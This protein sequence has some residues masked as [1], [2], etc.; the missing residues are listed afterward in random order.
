MAVVHLFRNVTNANK[1]TF[2]THKIEPVQNLLN[3]VLYEELNA[4][5]KNQKIEVYNVD[6]GET[7]YA[8]IEE[9]K[10]VASVAVTVNG[11]DVSLDY[12]IQPDDFLVVMV[13]PK[14]TAAAAFTIGFLAG[15]LAGAAA[16][17]AIA[18]ATALITGLVVGAIIG[19]IIGG[20]LG[21]MF[22]KATHKNKQQAQMEGTIDHGEGGRNLPDVRG[23]AN[24]PILG[25]SFPLLFGKHLVTPFI[26]GNS[27]NEIVGETGEDC[28]LNILY[29][30]GY[31]PLRLTDFKVG[32][33]YLAHNRETPG[34]YR[35]TVMHGTLTGYNEE[36][37]GDIL[38]RWRNNEVRLEI[39]QKGG[40]EENFDVYGKLYPY[41]K[42]QKQVDAHMIHIHDKI[43]D[44]ITY[45]GIRFDNGYRTNTVMFTENCPV[46]IEVEIDFQSGIYGTRTHSDTNGNSAP[47]YIDIPLWVAVQWRYYNDSN[48]SSNAEDGTGWN[49]FT[50]LNGISPSV[51]TEA[52]R[53]AE[54]K[55]H[56]GNAFDVNYNHGWIG[57]QAFNLQRFSGAKRNSQERFVARYD[58]TP[59]ECAKMIGYQSDEASYDFIEVR[60]IR[61][62]PMYQNQ[63]KGSGG[64][65][66]WTFTDCS[67][68][69]YLRTTVF[70]KEKYK[71]HLDEYGVPNTIVPFMQRPLSLEMMN[72]L[73]CVALRVKAD[74]AGEIAGE[75]KKFNVIGE[76]FAPVFNEENYTWLPE[77]VT[78]QT[79]W[80]GD[81]WE[82]I[83]YDEY[84]ERRQ[85]GE[86][87]VELKSGNDLQKKLKDIAFNETTYD[88]EKERYKLTPE[89][90]KYICANSAS[91][92]LLALLGMHLGKD[93]YGYEDL[94]MK[95]FEDMY[96]FCKDVTD[97][98]TYATTDKEYDPDNPDQL[99]HVPFNCNGYIYRQTKLES[100]LAKVLATGRA[101]FTRDE[102][103]RLAVFVDKPRD[104]PVL[105]INQQNCIS[106]NNI[107]S[108][109]EVPSGLLM[110]F[111]DE[112]DN[113]QKNTFYA[114]ADGEDYRQPKKAIEDYAIDF[115][116]NRRQAWSLGRYCLAYKLLGREATVRTIGAEGMCLSLGDM[117]SVSDDTLLIGSDMG[118]RVQ[119]LIQ[120][121]LYIYGFV[122]DETFEYTGEVDEEG[123]SVQGV[124]VI[125][126]CEYKESRIVTIRLAPPQGIYKQ[127][128][129][130]IKP[131][132]GFTNE[133][134]FE[135]PIVR[136]THKEYDAGYAI[137][138]TY[139]PKTENIVAFGK[140]GAISQNYIVNKIKPNDKFQFELTLIPYLAESYEYG[141]RLPVWQSNISQPKH[142]ESGN[143]DLKDGVT[144]GDVI[145]LISESI[146]NVNKPDDAR[147]GEV[148]FLSAIA[149][150]N[151]LD[152]AWTFDFSYKGNTEACY[153]IRFSKDGGKT[154][155]AEVTTDDAGYVVT[156]DGIC[157]GSTVF[158]YVFDRE[159]DGY[160]E[161][162]DF[163]SVVIGV[164]AKSKYL[165]FGKEKLYSKIDT[166][167]YGTWK[168]QQPI[169]KTSTNNRLAILTMTQPP[170]SDGREV[171][172]KIS[173]QVEIRKPG[174]D[175]ADTFFKPA[176]NKDP[177]EDELNYRDGSGYVLS[178]SIFQQSL[179]FSGQSSFAYK[180][181][182]QNY[183]NG[184]VVSGTTRYGNLPSSTGYRLI[185]RTYVGN[186]QTVYKQIIEKNVKGIIE[187]IESTYE[188]LPNPVATE[189][190]YRITAIGTVNKADPITTTVTI[191][192]TSS[193][194][195]I[196]SI[197]TQN[198]LAPDSVT[199][200]KIAT[201]TIT[202]DQIAAVDLAAKGATFGNL[203]AEGFRIDENNFWA[204]KTWE[205]PEKTAHKGQFWVGGKDQYLHVDPILGEGNEIVGY[206]IDFKVGNFHV[207]AD[208]SNIDGELI[209]ASSTNLY[210]R[211][212]IT[213][214]GTFYEHRNE[215][216]SPW[217]AVTY[218]N[219]AGTFSPQFYT[220]HTM[221]ITNASMAER[222][223]I[224][225][226]VGVPYLSPDARVYH[227]DTDV[228][229]QNGNNDLN[230]VGTNWQLVGIDNTSSNADLA[231]AIS[232]IAPYSSIGKSIYGRYTL[233]ADI[234][235]TNK[236][237]VDFW[238]KYYSNENQDLFSCGGNGAEFGNKFSVVVFAR[239]PYYE[240]Y[241]LPYS[242][243]EIPYDEALI[244]NSNELYKKI[245]IVDTTYE[246]LD[247]EF[248]YEAISEDTIP[249]ERITDR[250][251]KARYKYYLRSDIGIISYSLVHV[252]ARTFTNY[253]RQGL[254][255]HWIP[256]NAPD[257]GGQFLVNEVQGTEERISFKQL[258][259]DF[260]EGEWIHIAVSADTEEATIMFGL[261]RKEGTKIVR[262]TFFKDSIVAPQ[263]I[264]FNKSKNTFILDELYIDT[265]VTES[266]EDF[267][268]HTIERK[269]WASMSD[270]DDWFI[271][272]VKDTNK[273][274][275]NLFESPVFINKVQ[276]IIGTVNAETIQPIIQEN[277][278]QAISETMSSQ[279]EEIVNNK[280]RILEL[281]DITAPS[282]ADTML[283]SYTDSASGKKRWKTITKTEFVNSLSIPASK[284]QFVGT[285][286]QWNALSD[287][288]KASYD[289]KEVIITDDE[290]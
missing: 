68:W 65:S 258:G 241:G 179:P 22:Y 255:E 158:S 85:N 201:G 166:S 163:S 43:L 41:T 35:D 187:R 199:A 210:D 288:A 121:D 232:A 211:T 144:A 183:E 169:I 194:D 96:L 128:G 82:E 152:I 230:I 204:G 64:N 24:Q 16:G 81:N 264:T 99:V 177:Y 159:R 235:T 57:C 192:P 245:E 206:T 9:D 156:H 115:V 182:I 34:R 286:S 33:L 170:R 263:T 146:N 59:E 218:M 134:I 256:Y 102:S 147:T 229:D 67:K 78:R 18:G 142:D 226:D 191:T 90:E 212:R 29:C 21:Y 7:T 198:K 162:E 216:T 73:C 4:S 19:G 70:D 172:G 110:T 289:K 15:A 145:E 269:P 149:Y 155:S 189:Y 140:I 116:T 47:E 111:I 127:D 112:T 125:Q 150:E 11:K 195:L 53:D 267:Y 231:P 280:I 157:I 86:Q 227:F 246:D 56:H 239:E 74:A 20:A 190:Q 240:D 124:E 137:K 105:M 161:A 174:T 281:E 186:T 139:N 251:F 262:R 253:V 252:T 48:P 215:V 143:F 197:I 32:E 98:S 114:M 46:S 50:T 51:Y 275:T 93:A 244:L 257:E 72:K 148:E 76:S 213:P 27:W 208:S 69:T 234:G 1:D 129:E 285:R 62:T 228:Y 274:K 39:L 185:E 248:R 243:S 80:Y 2:E 100:F 94:N 63:Q 66:G 160:P 250:P 5:P 130:L 193:S 283:I 260:K 26:L 223:K 113:Y 37:T 188:V 141:R 259:L 118:A 42:I 12:V 173:Y 225:Y 277:I 71:K 91:V 233:G 273:V 278:M 23:S 101:S 151:S 138:Y 276:E 214:I 271:L 40:D 14:A 13:L 31:A 75:L 207:S 77:N 268:L 83:T 168:V 265:D 236:Y 282:A 254:Y 209:V 270:E 30:I 104:F 3:R 222:R 123:R 25:N 120:D 49:T 165:S 45:Q 122:T 38:R 6:T 136:E 224:G 109:A 154:W 103:N 242:T 171:Y 220:D 287:T 8:Y 176:I 181:I 237:V 266:L 10:E 131:C 153:Y 28:Y 261:P 79:K 36:D 279:I 92:A 95:S 180:N 44:E 54:A 52:A 119:A 132:V 164:T 89:S 61:V 126:P 167:R 249:Y 272:H 133:V 17:A 184:K 238:I 247:S 290:E 117:V 84:I 60:V 87:A 200:E 107:R 175:S 202:A 58:F 106:S 219:N 88:E 217:Y 284:I 205:F 196:D 135:R 178:E 97:G 108:F 203:A 55:K 221:F